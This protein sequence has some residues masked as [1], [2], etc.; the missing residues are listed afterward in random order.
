MNK[1]YKDTINKKWYTGFCTE[2]EKCWC[3]TINTIPWSLERFNNDDMGDCIVGSGDIEKELA[4]HIVKIH[5]E[6]LEN[7]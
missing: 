5:N 4:F 1:K 2:G 3:R 7:N 6:W